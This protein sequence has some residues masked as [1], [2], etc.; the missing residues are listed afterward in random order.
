MSNL[1]I[2]GSGRLGRCCLDIARKQYQKISFLDDNTV[3]SIINDCNVIGTI[4]EMSSYYPEYTNIVIAIGNNETRKKLIDKAREV[5]Y[6]LVS[7]VSD[8]A[9][10]SSYALVNE[11]NIILDNV[12][13]EANASI[14]KGNIICANTTINHDAQ[15]NNYNLIYS[16][17]VI[18][19]SAVIENNI[20]I[21][22]LSLITSKM[23]KE[24]NWEEEHVKQYGEVSFF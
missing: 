23:S 21:E 13:I 16:N 12:V 14:G 8:K 22:N 7:L 15:I 19:P 4:D 5:G 9:S 10:V 17:C 11:A 24:N 6:Q 1:L 20:I 18:R 2:I 3:N